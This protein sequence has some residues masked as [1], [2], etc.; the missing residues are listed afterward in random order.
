MSSHKEWSVKAKKTLEKARKMS[1]EEVASFIQGTDGDVSPKCW[2][3]AG[4]AVLS[5]K[6][7]DRII[8]FCFFKGAWVIYEVESLEA[9]EKKVRE[10]NFFNLNDAQDR[11]RRAVHVVNRRFANSLA[12]NKLTPEDFKKFEVWREKL[13]QK[14]P[15]KHM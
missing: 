1:V 2:R 6:K 5:D 3:K 10:K 9:F 4:V 12:K 7:N 8:R 13:I 14:D 15:T 11:Y